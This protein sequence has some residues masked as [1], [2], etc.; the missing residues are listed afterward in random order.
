MR[1]SSESSSWLGEGS[2]SPRPAVGRLRDCVIAVTPSTSNQLEVAELVP[3][4]VLRPFRFPLPPPLYGSILTVYSK[5]QNCM[6]FLPNMRA[7][8]EFISHLKLFSK[9]SQDENRLLEDYYAAY[10]RMPRHN[11]VMRDVE[12]PYGLR[13][14]VLHMREIY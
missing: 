6:Q 2:E 13:F 7:Y 9:S 4:H 1:I 11:T 14:M 10:Y 8:S 5:I 3:I 12:A